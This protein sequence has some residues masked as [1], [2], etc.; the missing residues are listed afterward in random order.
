MNTSSCEMELVK[1]WGLGHLGLVDVAI[2]QNVC[3]PMNLQEFFSQ[4]NTRANNLRPQKNLCEKM[5][6]FWQNAYEY[7]FEK[8]V[9][10][11]NL[12]LASTK[13]SY[14]AFCQFAFQGETQK[15]LENVDV[16]MIQREKKMLLKK[17]N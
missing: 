6:G 7:I 12:F 9:G 8:C 10:S 11:S 4:A 2:Q 15:N 17:Q 16:Q 14:G 13:R 1:S 3:A 5:E